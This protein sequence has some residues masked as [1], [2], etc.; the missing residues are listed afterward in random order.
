M[1]TYFENITNIIWLLLSASHK[2]CCPKSYCHP[3]DVNLIYYALRRHTPRGETG[4]MRRGNGRRCYRCKCWNTPGTIA[5]HK[6]NMSTK[7]II[8]SKPKG[9][10][11]KQPFSSAWD[12]GGVCPNVCPGEGSCTSIKLGFVYPCVLLW[13]RYENWGKTRSKCTALSRLPHN[14]RQLE[15]V[16]QEWGVSD[17]VALSQLN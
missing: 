9:A 12:T 1:L 3:A 6:L 17:D 10:A 15:L 16:A 14:M 11:W 5:T 7:E 8:K 13:D 2:K 4:V